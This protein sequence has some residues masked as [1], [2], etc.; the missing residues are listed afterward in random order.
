MKKA[1]FLDR[2]GVINKDLGYVSKIEDFIFLEGVID[3]L[4]IFKRLGYLIIIITNQ[5]GIARG[6]FSSTAYQKLTKKYLKIL[7]DKGIEISACY[8]CPHHPEFSAS[9]FNNCD[10]RKPKDGMFAK[11]IKEF[12]LDIMNSIAIGD[13]VRDLSPA[14]D[15][16]VSKKYLITS[17]I[18]KD[19][20]LVT[21]TFLSLI[22]CAEYISNKEKNNN[23][24]REN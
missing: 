12:N 3:A 21:E 5:S 22:E 4:K 19:D 15:L 8:H 11:A 24:F 7:Y 23:S 1:I 17:S 18:I 14:H 10:C 16:G 6:Y 2:D 20:L 9:P 13:K